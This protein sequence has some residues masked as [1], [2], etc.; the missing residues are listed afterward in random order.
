MNYLAHGFRVVDDPDRV[1]GTALPDWLAACDRGVRLRHGQLDESFPA[2][3][4]GVEQHW[5]EDRRF[6][7]GEAFQTVEAELTARIRHAHPDH[8]RLRAWFLG[9]VLTEMLLDAAVMV[10]ARSRLDHYYD[11][12][13]AVDAGGVI[14]AVGRWTGR[15][16]VGLR[17]Y[18]DAFRR[19]RYLYGYME[20]DGL[21]RRLSRV[22]ER[23]GLPPLPPTIAPLL[24]GMRR[25]VTARADDLLADATRTPHSRAPR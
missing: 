22:A 18:I 5:E 25:L 19:S 9:H 6:H 13:E 11:A 17:L 1:A 15:L 7:A 12:L 20:D 10:E 21:F 23:V 16:P 3:R 14:A 2:L 4:A 8:P 24:P